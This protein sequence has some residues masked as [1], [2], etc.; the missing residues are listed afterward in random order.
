LFAALAAILWAS[1]LGTAT[2]ET[3]DSWL[4]I[5]FAVA[6][7]GGTGLSGGVISGFGILMGGAIFL[8]IKHGLVEIKANPYFADAF[9]GTLILLAV[10]IDRVREVY[11]LKSSFHK[12]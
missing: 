11:L 10:V 2:P 1:Q 7:I 12:K 4:I 6:I 3:G 9:L 8:L 5:S